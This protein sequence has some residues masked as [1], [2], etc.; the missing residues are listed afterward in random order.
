[1]VKVHRVSGFHQ[2]KIDANIEDVWALV[3]DWGSLAWYDDGTNTE[4]M[5]LMESWLEGEPGAVPRTRVMSRGDGAVEHGAPEENREV[6]LVEDHVAHRLYYDATDGFAP[7]IRNYMA[8]WCF[9]ELDDGGCLM[10]ISSNFDC[11]PADIGEQHGAM[12]HGVYVSI[13]AS[14]QKYFTKAQANARMV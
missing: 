11:V 1:M 7:G 9:D 2:G 14:L 6:L 8:S 13:V 4:G 5:K 3:T 10:T 12:L